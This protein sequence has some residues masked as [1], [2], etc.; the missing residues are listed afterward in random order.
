MYL[1]QLCLSKRFFLFLFIEV[2]SGRLKGIV[3][4]VHTWYAAIPID[5]EIFIL[6]YIGWRVLIIWTFIFSQ[7]GCFCQFLMG[8]FG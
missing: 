2:M 7:F 1:G 5:L 8:N 4:S 3:L 6:Q